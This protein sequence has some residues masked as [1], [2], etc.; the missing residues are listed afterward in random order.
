MSAHEEFVKELYFSFV[1]KLTEDG[2]KHPLIK[3]KICLLEAPAES[4][5][6]QI[7]EM[8]YEDDFWDFNDIS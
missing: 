5:R 4:T 8:C 1:D 7:C 3:C 6:S 2:K